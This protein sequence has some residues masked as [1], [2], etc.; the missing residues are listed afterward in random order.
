MPTYKIK[1]KKNSCQIKLIPAFIIKN[2]NKKFDRQEHHYK[3]QLYLAWI[4]RRLGLRGVLLALYAMEAPTVDA[5]N[6]PTKIKK[7]SK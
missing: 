4:R 2:P 3:M 1:N 7:K 5:Q 6:A